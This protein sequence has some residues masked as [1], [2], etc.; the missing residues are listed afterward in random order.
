[1]DKA[2][3]DASVRYI[4]L[5]CGRRFGKTTWSDMRASEVALDGGAVGWF[6]PN[7]D[8]ADPVWE[9]W[10]KRFASIT[11]K[12]DTQARTLYLHT[13][14]ILEMWTLHNT[15]D[16]G[17]SRKYDLAVVDEAGLIG[18]LDKVWRGAI[19][20]TLW[21]RRGRG[22]LAGTP[23]GQRTSFNVLH[24][25]AASGSAGAQ[26]RAF[27]KGSADNPHLPPGEVEEFRRECER[28]GTLW[29]YEQ[30]ALGIPADDGSNPIGLAA[31]QRAIGPASVDEHG[32]PS[33]IAAVGIDL[34][35]SLDYTALYS[36]DVY[37]RWV[38]VER[39]QAPWSLTKR[40]L[41]AWLRRHCTTDGRNLTVPVSVDQSGV[42]SPIVGDL[43]TM[44][45]AV[46]GVT[47]TDSSRR[48]LLERLIVDV[49]AGRMSLPPRDD[50]AGGFVVSELES[51]GAETL[52]SGKVRYAVPDGMHD[53]GV[54]ALALC[55]HA[56][57][58]VSVPPHERQPSV[59][60]W[61]NR[62]TRR[63]RTPKAPALPQPMYATVD[64]QDAHSA[65]ADGWEEVEL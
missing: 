56:Y 35:Q 45:L 23:K 54:M 43:H 57:R 24:E 1:M 32:E 13:G 9:G 6:T 30:E 4:S 33:P 10:V 50:P 27:Q 65:A 47:F 14:G 48:V 60:D 22:L 40:R 11:R 38:H 36:V 59:A 52:P 34:A 44:G 25:L 19:R 15:E 16:P 64:W 18:N 39:W 62:S 5:R 12:R 26:W 58:G 17:R 61:E 7:S 3:A 37:G 63:R 41:A 55:C 21:D 29:L 51:L 28:N 46:Q 8:Y 53:D 49:Q 31:I 42:G 20:P 2:W